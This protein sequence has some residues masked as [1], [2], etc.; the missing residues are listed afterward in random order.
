MPYIQRAL[1]ADKSSAEAFHLLGDASERIGN[2][3]DAVHAYQTAAKLSPTETN[4]FDL[5]TEMLTHLA[6]EAAMAVFK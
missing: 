5:G 2:S 6:P 3:L 4:I 1:A